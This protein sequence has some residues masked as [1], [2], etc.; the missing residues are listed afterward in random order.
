MA[1]LL[2]GLKTLGAIRAGA[3]GVVGLA[4]LG[5][6]LFVAMRGGQGAM[7]PLG[8]ELDGRDSAQVALALEKAR[9]PFQFTA[10]NQL[11]VAADDVP[12]ARIALAK[13][14]L[15]SGG[16]VGYEIFDRGEGLGTTQFQQQLNQ[17]RALEGELARSIRTLSGVRSARVHLVMPRREPFARDR[18][19]ARASVVLALAGAA[20]LDRDQTRAI[21]NLVTGAVPGL[22]ANNV[23]VVDSQGNVLAENGQMSDGEARAA[24][25]RDEQ[26][27]I[28]ERQMARGVEEML[29]RTL[30]PGRVRAEA[31]LDYDYDKVNETQERFDP[32]GQVMRSQQ[33]TMEQSRSTEASAN[34]SVQNNLPNPEGANG[35]TGGTQESRQEETSNYEISRS[36]RTVVRDQPVLRRLSLAVMVDHVA[37]RAA[38]GTV[39]WRERST[40]ELA[41]IATLVRSAVGFD[42][43]RGDIVEVASMAFAAPPAEEAQGAAGMLGL[44]LERAELF[45]IGEAALAILLFLVFI[46]AFARPT[47]AR[48]VSLSPQEAPLQSLSAGGSAALG[49][50]MSPPLPPL[51][52]AM[53]T[54][55]QVDGQVRAA[56][57]RALAGLVDERPEE[58][59]QTLRNW[60]ATEST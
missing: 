18:Q 34:V 45:R 24:T 27:R 39:T 5:F 43:R 37:E 23:A 16:M 2:Q 3:I 12:R 35:S 13:E 50:A 11:L 58:A 57:L 22:A 26:R 59:V 1:A 30:G 19:E 6:L 31:A 20:R 56:S 32:D 29:E 38:D 51:E 42:E 21:V 33:S 52:E 47:V 28:A 17:L 4:V 7:T 48:L 55:A 15:P 44:P 53:V 60:L 9:I 46:Y 36:V 8:A 54:M 25:T 14:G 49:A 10:G 40:E 41:R